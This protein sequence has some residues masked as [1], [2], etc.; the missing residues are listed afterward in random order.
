MINTEY[1]VSHT[2]HKCP[3]IAIAFVADL[4]QF[5]PEPVLLRLVSIQPYVVALPG[6]L[7]ESHEFGEN[8]D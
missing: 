2:A 6:D 4:H 1:R 3:A 7:F 8:L 5:N